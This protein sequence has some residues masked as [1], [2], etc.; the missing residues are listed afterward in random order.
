MS[1][2]A[3]D[4]CETCISYSDGE[5][6]CRGLCV[7]RSGAPEKQLLIVLCHA[8]AGIDVHTKD[9]AKRLA[10]FGF[11]VF[12]PDM[13]GDGRV[14]LSSEEC[15]ALKRPFVEDRFLLQRRIT[16]GFDIACALDTRDHSFAP[17]LVGFGFGGMCALH[18]AR[19]GVSV[20]GLA[21]VYGH[22][23]PPHRD[24]C[25]VSPLNVENVAIFHGSLDSVAPRS[26]LTAFEAELAKSKVRSW[27]IHLF[28]SAM[29][30]FATPSAN[31]AA[32]GVMYDRNSCEVM[33]S[34]L[35]T[36]LRIWIATWSAQ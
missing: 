20:L 19:S 16:S 2:P 18:L 33:W 11:L 1:Q 26:E 9:N 28:G 24:G 32:A 30:A 25:V 23:L 17:I 29:H 36:H 5:T 13:F 4:F 6:P 31:N 21:V 12:V 34:L 3:D 14:G 15:A 22:F 35:H 8:W 10:S 7:T 27:Q